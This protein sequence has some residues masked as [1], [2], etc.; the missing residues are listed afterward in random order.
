MGTL[1]ITRT[2]QAVNVLRSFKILV[3][4][5]PVGA[6]AH[7]KVAEFPVEP[8][9]HEV[10]AKIDWCQTPAITVSV[11]R[12][13][14]VELEVGCNRTSWHSLGLLWAVLV[15]PQTY[16]YLRAPNSG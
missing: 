2:R 5:K 3:D 12:G 7:G 1:K 14:T 13:G 15:R 8:G 9:F 16:L 10:A 11:E 6:V 4:G